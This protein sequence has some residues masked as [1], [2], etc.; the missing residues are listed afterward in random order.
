M[1][2]AATRQVCARRR[3]TVGG[4]TDR[5]YPLLGRLSV[6]PGSGWRGHRPHLDQQAQHVRLGEAL[7]DPVAAEV[8]DGARAA[9]P[10]ATVPAV[11]LTRGHGTAARFGSLS[12]PPPVTAAG[13][14][15]QAGSFGP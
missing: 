1:P 10:F 7:D 5:P 15:F 11:R 8:Q 13:C 6:P 4:Q 14:A 2:V 12:L 3:L 9:W